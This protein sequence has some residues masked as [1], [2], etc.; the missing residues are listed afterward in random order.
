MHPYWCTGGL[1]GGERRHD[2]VLQER[3]L[4]GAL[5]FY[6]AMQRAGGGAGQTRLIRA[7]LVSLR[8]ERA[9]ARSN[10]PRPHPRGGP[11]SIRGPTTPRGFA[12]PTP[13]RRAH[14]VPN[15]SGFEP[16]TVP[17]FLVL[18]Q[19]PS[20][21]NPERFAL[22]VSLPPP[23]RAA[24]R[25]SSRVSGGC[26]I[27]DQSGASPGPRSTAA[28]LPRVFRPSHPP[29]RP[30]PLPEDPPRTARGPSA[31]RPRREKHILLLVLRSGEVSGASA[32]DPAPRR[33]RARSGSSRRACG[34]VGLAS[35]FALVFPLVFALAPPKFRGGES[36]GADP[37][38]G[39]VGRPR[40]GPRRGSRSPVGEPIPPRCPPPP[41]RTTRA[42]VCVRVHSGG[43]RGGDVSRPRRR[44]VPSA[45]AVNTA[46]GLLRRV[47]G[48]GAASSMNS[49]DAVVLPAA[50]P[51]PRC[52]NTP[53]G[54]SAG[55]IRRGIDVGVVRE[56]VCEGFVGEERSRGARIP[57]RRRRRRR[58]PRRRRVRRNSDAARVPS[59]GAC[60]SNGTRR[61][62]RRA[63]S[64][65]ATRSAG[66][67]AAAGGT[68]VAGNALRGPIDSARARIPRADRGPTAR[69]W[70]RRRGGRS[71][72]DDTPRGFRASFPPPPRRRTASG[73]G[74]DNRR[75]GGKVSVDAR[76]GRT[77]APAAMDVCVAA[78]ASGRGVP[79][80]CSTARQSGQRYLRVRS[81]LGGASGSR[82]VRGGPALDPRATS[83][84]RSRRWTSSGSRSRR[85]RH[86]S[87]RWCFEPSGDAN[88]RGMGRRGER[89]G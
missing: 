32:S 14:G 85:R 20:I 73:F 8:L 75:L 48:G 67:E 61:A 22:F 36:A 1:R 59:T 81:V 12:S 52:R 70:S 23:D 74:R 89:R 68:G 31:T 72:A 84:D 35:P 53:P 18:F 28:H 54:A 77:C 58:L 71:N 50:A 45:A 19:H 82:Q 4:F 63:S 3:V 88:R 69:V 46:A 5:L 55:R 80:G 29:R 87:S 21:A 6:G 16:S 60:A 25:R 44:R 78:A 64:D 86:R 49:E 38:V 7:S 65:S 76:P 13:R 9:G 27:P 11:R 2:H 15:G 37:R 66:Q 24:S 79:R 34:V 40:E 10:R 30:P 17:S 62:T 43:G 56:V 33:S 41:Q 83:T 57:P 47:P 42:G 51:S 39:R 26:L